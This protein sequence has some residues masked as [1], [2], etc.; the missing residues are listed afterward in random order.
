LQDRHRFQT[1]G[2][3]LRIASLKPAVMTPVDAYNGCTE[4]AEGTAAPDMSFTV[5][6]S[7]AW[8]R[9]AWTCEANRSSNIAEKMA[10]PRR[11]L[12]ISSRIEDHYTSKYLRCQKIRAG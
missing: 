2:R 7:V 4:M 9:C 5:P 6:T 8:L 3:D 10:F 11:I 12:S 1:G